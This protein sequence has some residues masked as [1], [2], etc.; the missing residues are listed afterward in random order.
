VRISWALAG[1]LIGEGDVVSLFGFCVYEYCMRILGVWE[2]SELD[3]E[4]HDIKCILYQ[5]LC[6]VV[7]TCALI[8]CYSE[9]LCPR[10]RLNIPIP[11]RRPQVLRLMEEL[12][13]ESRQEA[14][15]MYGVLWLVNLLVGVLFLSVGETH[16]RRGQTW[17]RPRRL[18]RQRDGAIPGL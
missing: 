3:W 17:K 7:E 5:W 15:T 8:P 2:D 11:P 1:D 6:F 13:T 16:A 14:A 4:N 10:I 9:P 18:H 12:P